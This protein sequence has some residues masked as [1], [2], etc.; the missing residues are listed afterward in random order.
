[1]ATEAE[2]RTW[3]GTEDAD[4]ALLADQWAKV[5]AREARLRELAD[6]LAQ[7]CDVWERIIHHRVTAAA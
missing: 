6:E 3:T 5:R 2:R 7:Q 4:W 1:M